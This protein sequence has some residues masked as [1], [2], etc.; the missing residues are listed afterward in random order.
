VLKTDEY[1][2]YLEKLF[3]KVYVLLWYYKTNILL[4]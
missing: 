2:E 1:D 3:L 4:C